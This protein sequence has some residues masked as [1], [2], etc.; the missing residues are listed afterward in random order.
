VNSL[1]TSLIAFGAIL[2]GVFVGSVLR[3]RLPEH[4]L[5]ED[6]KDV[7]K[8]GTG[9]VATLTALVLGLLISSS[10]N[11]YDTAE[12]G[13]TKNGAAVISLDRAMAQYGPETKDA[14]DLLRRTLISVIW[15]GWPEDA[16][17]LPKLEE[18]ERVGLESVHAK[19]QQLTPKTDAQRWFHSQALDIS[20]DLAQSRWQLVEQAQTSLPVPLLVVL[21]LWLTVLFASFGLLAPPNATV[22]TVLVICALSAA[23][24]VFV[25]VELG[26]PH[27]GLLKVSSAPLL[28][29]LSHLGR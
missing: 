24:A 19:L 2:C 21:V 27:E 20:G 25:V 22:I 18:G 8:I 4:H 13:I 1:V 16:A 12:G 15:R 11:S 5:R 23:A 17:S 6:S 3:T 28:K 10:K 26:H 29:A 7:V 9:L 14:R